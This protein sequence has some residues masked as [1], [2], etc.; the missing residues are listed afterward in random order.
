MFALSKKAFRR[1]KA[2]RL[3]ETIIINK[4]NEDYV[5]TVFLIHKHCA[6]ILIFRNFIMLTVNRIRNWIY[7][8]GFPSQ[9]SG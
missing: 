6:I 9:S 8:A 4:P 5:C 2:L 1:L 3:R 7:W